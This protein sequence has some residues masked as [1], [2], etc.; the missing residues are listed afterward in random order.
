MNAF[1][2]REKRPLETR[3]ALDPAAVSRFVKL[4]ATVTLESAAGTAAGHPDD[5]YRN[6]GALI[7]SDPQKA[8]AEAD[9]VLR[10]RP[11]E[12]SEISRQKPGS[13]AVGFMDPFSNRELIDAMVARGVTGVCME[14]IPRTTLAQKMDALSSQANLAGYAAVL[15]AANRLDAI[16]PMMMTPAG[17]ISPAKV[18]IIGVGVAG[19]QAIATARRLGARVEAFDTRPVVEEQVR[20]LGAKFVKIDIGETGQ[21]EQGYARELT[22]RQVAM[23]Q[24]GMAKIC[25]GADIVITTAKVFGRQ[26]PRL[27]TAEM[28]TGMRPGAVVV[29]LAAESG[30]NVEGTRL[31]EEVV[32]DHGVR[33]LG[34]GAP[35]CRVPR[36]ASQ[37]YASNLSSFIEH[38]WNAETGTPDLD[39]DDE[40][41]KGCLLV[42]RGQIQERFKP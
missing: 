3:V 23:Q 20:S 19:L 11:P 24:A 41:L 36:H 28:L 30:G 35:E 31:D 42:H 32:L 25:A 10:V 8:L 16:L 29:D 38:F 15:M 12:A 13:A 6:A 4:G 34:W 27:L 14:L 37:M 18:F 1:V 17:T 33:L 2:C 9:F 5:A 26:A 39:R 40:I 22:A 21:T 7:A